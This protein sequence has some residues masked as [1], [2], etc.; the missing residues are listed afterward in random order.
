MKDNISEF[1]RDLS[2]RH[3]ADVDAHLGRYIMA[4]G[5]ISRVSIERSFDVVRDGDSSKVKVIMKATLHEG[6]GNDEPERVKAGG[7]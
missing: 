2:S 1:I 6:V 3:I 7:E 4:G 5:D